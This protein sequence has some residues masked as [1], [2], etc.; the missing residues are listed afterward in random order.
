MEQVEILRRMTEIEHTFNDSRLGTVDHIQLCGEY[1]LLQG[2][3]NIEENRKAIG[4]V[5]VT[6]EPRKSSIE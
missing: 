5:L 6:G 4:Q 1:S 3:L 2:L